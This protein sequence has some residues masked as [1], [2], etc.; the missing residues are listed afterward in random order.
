M[1]GVW[2]PDVKPYVLGKDRGYNGEGIRESKTGDHEKI[3]VLEVQ[4]RDF[5]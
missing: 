4:G 3:L 1:V 2:I 5:S